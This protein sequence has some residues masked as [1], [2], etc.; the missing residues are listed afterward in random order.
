[1]SADEVLLTSATK[2]ILPITKVD[3]LKIGKGDCRGKPGKIFKSL[4][5]AYTNLMFPKK[6]AT[7]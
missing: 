7:H 5:V 6:E 3:G 1:M 4:R 2:E